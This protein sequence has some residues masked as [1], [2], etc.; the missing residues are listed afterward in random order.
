MTDLDWEPL[1]RLGFDDNGLLEV[2]HIVGIFNYLTRL[3]DGMGLALD[4]ETDEAS[5]TG[6]ALVRR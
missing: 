1:S 2:A 6:I 5:R 4:A 3:A